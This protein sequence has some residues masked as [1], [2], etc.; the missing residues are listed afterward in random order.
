MDKKVKALGK[1]EIGQENSKFHLTTPALILDL[2][3]MEENIALM[4]QLA[5]EKNVKLRPHCK[6]HKSV[7]IAKLQMKAGAVGISCATIG[8]AEVMV[9]AQIPGV[10]ITSQVVQES[11]VVRLIALH[12]KAQDLM[13]V[14]DHLDNVEMLAKANE[15]N[16]PLQVLIDYDIGQN[17]TGVKSHEEAVRLAHKIFQYRFLKLVGIQ[18]YGGHFQHIAD[19]Q[20]RKKQIQGQNEKIRELVIEV[21]KLVPY[22][23]IMTGG[24]TGTFDIDRHEGVYT[25]L[26]VGSYL[27]MDVEYSDVALFS[28]GNNRFKPSLFV[29]ATVISSHQSEV[30][31][32]AGLKA[33]ATD[34]PLPR[35]VAGALGTY[36]FKGDEH[37]KVKIVEGSRVPSL[38]HTLE[39]LTPHCDP[40][41]NLYDFYHCVRGN[42]LVDIWPIEARGLH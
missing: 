40:T 2:D 29:L 4:A 32:D 19:Y 28:D 31:V 38:G 39:F 33:F 8:E 27:F 3:A 41:V 37:G 14:V 24:G 1:E 26:Q 5:R 13:V 16:R 25:E 30:I 20:E 7:Q 10:L 15:G 11:K 9:E 36:E 34:G 42:K 22:Y 17:R 23:L 12:Q 35:V 6:S 21:Q 18:A